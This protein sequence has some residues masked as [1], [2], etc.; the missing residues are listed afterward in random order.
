VLLWALTLLLAPA[1]IAAAPQLVDRIVAVVDDEIVLHSEVL[2]QFRFASIEE[3]LDPQTMSDLRRQ[4]L[5]AKILENMVQNEL[6]LARARKD[7]VE[8]DDELVEAQVRSRIRELKAE[9][10]EAGYQELLRNEG[11]AEREVREQLRQ[12]MREMFLRQQ[13]SQ[14]LAVESE[15]SYK[16]VQ[17][18]RLEYENSLPPLMGISHILVEPRPAA[19]RSESARAR[20][21]ALHAQI[22]AGADFAAIARE[23]SD[24]R[25]TAA[26]GGDL[27]GFFPRGTY[28]PEL[29]AAAFGLEAGE[30]SEVI[31]TPLGY[32][33]VKVDE[34]RRDEIKAR[35]ILVSLEASESDVAVA[36]QEASKLA[37]AL[38]DGAD[39]EEL[40]K[41][42]SAHKESAEEGGRLPG[43]WTPENLPPGFAEVIRAMRLGEVSQ[44]VQS[45]F[46]WHLVKL[47]D[48]RDT[49]EEVVERL[50]M[51]ETFQELLDR[52][53]EE[54]YV[55]VRGVGP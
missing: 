28:F 50:R 12:R 21:E 46:G 24:D 20:A 15:V 48:D 52:T 39:F 38:R 13:M 3:G 22:Q 27:G 40:A 36:Y 37:E 9:H 26:E 53:R 25:G 45:E 29:E 43:L 31:E 6:L 47:N 32:I 17:A 44:P 42:H 41:A 30:V 34:V 2:S 5:Y 33:L 1:R 55:E 35:L 23:H 10:G 7:S 14:R 18:F 19:D 11:L 16:D 4:E 49:L 51:Q 54:L 8:V